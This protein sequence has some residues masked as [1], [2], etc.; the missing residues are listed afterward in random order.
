MRLESE[1]KAKQKK[2]NDLNNSLMA[3]LRDPN[4]TI[5]EHAKTLQDK[6]DALEVALKAKEEESQHLK[7]DCG[8]CHPAEH[9]Q[10]IEMLEE[11]NSI[12]EIEKDGHE[13]TIEA[14]REA[15]DFEVK[16]KVGHMNTILLLESQLKDKDA[17][18]KRLREE[19][20][21]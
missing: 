13:K 11:R 16:S 17:E 3:E 14:W 18:I 21:K 19:L 7:G 6:V 9:H 2:Y 4:G 8:L 5:W 12:L 15:Y 20:S 1:L 10:K